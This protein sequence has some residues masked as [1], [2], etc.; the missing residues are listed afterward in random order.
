MAV[1]GKVSF[2]FGTVFAEDASGNQR[3]LSIGD[4]IFEGERIITVAGAKVEMDM[5]SGD[6]ITVADGQSW[7]PT[8][9]TFTDSRDFAAADATLSPEDLAL[10]EALL[11]PGADPTQFGEATAAGAPGAGAPGTATGDGGTCFVTVKRTA[12][13]VNPDAGYETTGL[14]SK[15]VQPVL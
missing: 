15:I 4:E 14:D 5:L 7:S 13:E 2:L 8:G 1:I 3:L 6:Q 12:N 9:E 11:T 10:Q